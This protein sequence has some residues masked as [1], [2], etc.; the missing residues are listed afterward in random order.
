MLQ[1]DTEY[2]SIAEVQKALSNGDSTAKALVQ[3]CLNS[4]EKLD[5]ELNAI[6]A[7]NEHALEDAEKLDVST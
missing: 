1:A 6:T 4:I 7:V 5:P 2:R 3:Q